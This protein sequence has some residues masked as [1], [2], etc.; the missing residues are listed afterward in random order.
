MCWNI[1]YVWRIN[2][3]NSF[4][5]SFQITVARQL[6]KCRS[7][8]LPIRF[9]THPWQPED[10]TAPLEWSWNSSPRTMTRPLERLV[11]LVWFGN[12]NEDQVSLCFLP[13]L[14]ATGPYCNMKDIEGC[15]NPK[16]GWFSVHTTSGY[17][18]GPPSEQHNFNSWCVQSVER[19]QFDCYSLEVAAEST[20]IDINIFLR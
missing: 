14:E 8:W 9:E 10:L 15:N 20:L 13:S 16:N 11:W 6:P 1:I 12:K 5:I 17:L 4:R 2:F 3:S 7:D 18:V 19:S